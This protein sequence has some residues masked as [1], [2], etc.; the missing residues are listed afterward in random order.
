MNK[1]FYHLKHN[2]PQLLIVANDKEAS[3]AK[4]CGSYLGFEPFVLSDLR[5]N[6]GDDL[7]SFSDELKDIS[8]VL[9]QY[10]NYNKYEERI[11]NPSGEIMAHDSC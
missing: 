9:Q 6:W 3:I 7:L 5:A 4:D 8:A 11:I 2:K 1:I 10:H